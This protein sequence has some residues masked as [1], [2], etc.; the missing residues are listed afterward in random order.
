MSRMGRGGAKKSYREVD[1]DDDEDL[2]EDD[3]LPA[4]ASQQ[5]EDGMIA[6]MHDI[7]SVLIL[8]YRAC[9]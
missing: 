4:R 2:D 8:S 7:R 6:M 5:P 3:I 1:E 9:R